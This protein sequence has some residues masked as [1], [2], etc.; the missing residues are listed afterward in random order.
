[1]SDYDVIVIGSGANG[2][3]AADY[4]AKAGKS[5][6][7]FERRL[8]AGGGMSS[9]EPTINGFWHNTGSYVLD[10][11][12]LTGISEELNLDRWGADYIVPEL[13]SVLL[14]GDGTRL[15]VFT[16]RKRTVEALRSLSEK[17]A[18][19]WD[20]L[21]SFDYEPLRS[22]LG[23]HGTGEARRCR[24]EASDEGKELLRLSEMTAREAVDGLFESD[25]VKA[26]VLHHLLAPRGIGPDYPGTGGF[27]ALAVR[28]SHDGRA[29]R[30]GVHELAQA[31]WSGTHVLGSDVRDTCPVVKI[32]TDNGRASGVELKDGRAYSA[33]AV[34][35]TIDP[36]STLD[37]AGDDTLRTQLAGFES[38]EYSVFAVHAALRE[39]VSFSAGDDVASALRVSL[40]F[41]GPEDFEALFADV[42]AG[43]LPQQPR[44]L[45][46]CPTVIDPLQAPEGRHTLLIWQ[47]VPSRLE[48]QEW[49]EVRESYKNRC[50]AWLAEAAS[51]L[52]D[53]IIFE[54]AALTP[55]DFRQKWPNMSVGVF[56]GKNT[57][58]Q[59]FERRPVPE[60]GG[61]R[62]GKERLYLAGASAAPG[63]G[64]TGLPGMLA[65]RVVAE[66]LGVSP[67]WR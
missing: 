24:L 63:A 58:S 61:Y 51:N 5:V 20:R 40:G 21:A 16:D 50:I 62:T 25:A 54:S 4:L 65:A 33:D 26:L 10:S 19:Q 23:M 6:M 47:F 36:Q 1:M 52:N 7:V 15:E 64:I 53:G 35:S 32:L 8:E 9:E 28:L 66:D 29:V 18:S 17:D 34:I 11:L 60:L 49:A 3:V 31:L 45:V 43:K 59:L 48:N 57:G 27:A 30:T 42:R 44:M 41:D 56:G 38:D 2:L 46:A 39:P 13:Q 67:W 37:M 14:R 55:E 12:G 22:F